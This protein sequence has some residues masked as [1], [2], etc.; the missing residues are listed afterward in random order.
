MP[1]TTI[2]SKLL[3]DIQATVCGKR[4]QEKLILMNRTTIESKLLQDNQATTCG[5]KK[6]E[7][8]ILMPKTPVV[9]TNESPTHFSTFFIP[10]S[11]FP[12]QLQQ[13]TL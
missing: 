6:E 13:I 11:T 9:Y 5:K 8:P 3:Q 12:K 1:R 4:K 10:T 2:D 7:K